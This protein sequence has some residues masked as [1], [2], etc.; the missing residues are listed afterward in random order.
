MATR[1]ATRSSL[2][3]SIRL[4]PS[5]YSEAAPAQTPSG[6]AAELALD[7]NDRVFVR[8]LGSVAQREHVAGVDAIVRARPLDALDV[9]AAGGR[10]HVFRARR[11][12]P[13]QGC[14]WPRGCRARGGGGGCSS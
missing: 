14:R 9:F 5:A 1:S 4:S 12:R 13:R 11:S 10:H 7:A 6:L 8:E 3:M 2:I